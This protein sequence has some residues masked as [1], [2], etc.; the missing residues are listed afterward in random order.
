MNVYTE[1]L[2]ARRQI[3]GIQYAFFE[4]SHNFKGNF[5][6]WGGEGRDRDGNQ[7]FSTLAYK[8]KETC[9]HLPGLGS[10]YDQ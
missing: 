2:E 1:N 5:L 9:T 6:F 4:K 10:L 3:E 8:P 7:C